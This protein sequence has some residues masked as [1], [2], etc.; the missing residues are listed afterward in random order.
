M[1]FLWFIMWMIELPI[2]KACNS[3]GPLSD[4]CNT[5]N[6]LLQMLSKLSY[7]YSGAGESRIFYVL[8]LIAV[9]IG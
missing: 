1:E 2:T 7:E 4:T 9:K 3:V 8:N 5:L 6:M